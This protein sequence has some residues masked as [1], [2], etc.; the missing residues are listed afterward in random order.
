[1]KGFFKTLLASFLGVFAAMFLGVIVLVGIVSAAGA[2]SET[3]PVVPDSAILKIGG[4]LTLAE[5]SSDGDFDPSALFGGG[6]MNATKQVGILSAIQAIEKAASDPAIKFIYINPSQVNGA[7]SHLEE[8]RTAL[9]KF[10]ES[11]KAI[12]SYSETYSQ[13]GYYL[14]SV[15]DKMYVH[16]Y[17]GNMVFGVSTSLMFLK[18]ALDKLGIEVQLIRH[19][20]YKSA[21]EQFVNTNI[22]EANRE[23]NQAMITS[24][25]NSISEEICKSRNLDL[26]KFNAHVDNL[27]ATQPEEMVAAGMADGI[28]TRDEMTAE[29]AGLFGVEKEDDIKMI[30]LDK[31]AKAVIKPNI[32][33]TD[34]IAIIYAN[35]EIVDSGEGISPSKYTKVISDVRKDSTIK[36]VLLRVDSPGGSAMAAE[37]IR[38]ELELLRKEKPVVVSYGNYAAS[39]GY[40]ISAECDKIF[41]NETTL[42]GSIGVFSMIPNIEKIV[43][44]KA[45]INIVNI[46][47]NEHSD[48][49]TMTKPLDRAEAAYMQKGVEVIYDTFLSIV[50]NGR[51]MTTQEVDKIAQG[52]VWS[53][54]DAIKVDLADEIGTIYDAL[55]YTINISELEDYQLVE[56]PKVKSQMEK[57]MESFGNAESAISRL[58]DPDIALEDMVQELKQMSRTVYARM[59]Y[60]YVF[61]N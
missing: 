43:K 56:Y 32:K 7:I 50:A 29:L 38:K 9:V 23:Q 14:A 48:M 19:G 36:A 3:T 55:N 44:E 59:E 58:S 22:S 6:S 39:G 42:T 53:G 61:Q 17:G 10:K 54:T 27:S 20:K 2:A 21:G 16:P 49:M 28:M 35:G 47:S 12:I 24:L 33:A 18:G 51:D 45:R 34:K 60:D 26:K 30:T 37:I 1:M 5:Q 31:Y 8:F 11:G 41:T 15:A 25:W 46:N 4:N 57:I 13:G 52:R 40:W